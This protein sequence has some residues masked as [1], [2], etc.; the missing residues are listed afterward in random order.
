M[1]SIF[2]NEKRTFD[3]I[4]TSETIYNV[5]NQSKLISV[6]ENCLKPG[7]KVFLAAK[8]HYFGVGGGL[9]QF[10]EVLL[11]TGHWVFETVQKV[12]ST[13]K[14]EILLLTRK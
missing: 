2:K 6:F 4:I 14:R 7:G 9:R 5:S 3:L 8:T 13:V 10:E 11:K 1:E 12:E